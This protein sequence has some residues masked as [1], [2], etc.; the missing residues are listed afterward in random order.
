MAGKR[1]VIYPEWAERYRA[2]GRTIRKAGK[3]YALYRCTSERDADGKVKVKQTYLGMITQEDG[4]I[5]KR[6]AD[7]PARLEYGLSHFL[8]MNFKGAIGSHIYGRD[9]DLIKLA[10]IRFIF[11]TISEDTLRLSCLTCS[12]EHLLRNACRIN[13]QRI[14]RLAEWV[15]KE[16]RFRL[17]DPAE[18]RR[19]IMSLM[20]CTAEPGPQNSLRKVSPDRGV[21]EILEAHH[22]KY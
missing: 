21:M 12:D 18:Y 6:T 20:L 1:T 16:L 17:T 2:K 19:V 13:Q 5:P 3:G 14:E 10:I 15:E 8:W 22:L 4:F 9:E 7:A 11:G